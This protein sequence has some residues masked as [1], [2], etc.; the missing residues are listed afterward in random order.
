MS[1]ASLRGLVIVANIIGF[2]YNIPQLVLTIKTKSANDISGI[3]LILR[4]TSALLWIIYC[5]F[6][7]NIDVLI[8]WCVTGLCSTVLLYYKYIYKLS[9]KSKSVTILPTTNV[10]TQN[11]S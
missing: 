4:F 5:C 9:D 11:A 2:V 10:I 6:V 3:F 1:E 8:S 7:L